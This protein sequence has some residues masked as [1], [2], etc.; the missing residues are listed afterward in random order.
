MISPFLGDSEI[1]ECRATG[2][3]HRTSGRA[4][5]VNMTQYKTNKRSDRRKAEVEWTNLEKAHQINRGKDSSARPKKARDATRGGIISGREDEETNGTA[6][7]APLDSR[8]RGRRQAQKSFNY[9]DRRPA[10]TMAQFP[11]A[12]SVRRV[13]CIRAVV[14]PSPAGPRWRFSVKFMRECADGSL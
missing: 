12:G 5:I 1:S 14:C 7:I 2:D 10:L 13:I 9:S 3:A 8:H 4:M 11:A 6:S